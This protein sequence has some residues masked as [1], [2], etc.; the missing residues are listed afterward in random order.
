MLNMGSHRVTAELIATL[1]FSTRAETASTP[2]S[3]IGSGGKNGIFAKSDQLMTKCDF[4]HESAACH[5][6]HAN[7]CRRRTVEW[8]LCGLSLQV[9]CRP[10]RWKRA[11]SW[12]CKE[13]LTK[14]ADRRSLPKAKPISLLGRR[15]GFLCHAGKSSRHRAEV[16]KDLDN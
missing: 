8:Q 10:Y 15:S 1:P 11:G 13:E 9:Q 12:N 5:F 3:A 2:I 14:I 16:S 7:T 4:Y 6:R